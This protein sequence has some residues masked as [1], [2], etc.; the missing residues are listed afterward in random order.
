VAGTDVVQLYGR[1][2]HGSVV[3]PV[4]QLLGYQRVTLGPGESATVTFTVP[5]QRFAFSDRS[6]TRV[7]EPGDVEVW[8]GSHCS[9]SAAAPAEEATGGVIRNERV[10]ERRAVP[11]TATAR[12]LVRVSGEVHRV[13]LDDPR[14]VTVEVAAR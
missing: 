2:L 14:R 8:V 10:A 3:R 7:V 1:D 5:T 4:V 9:A 13:T 12:S 11:G 6:M